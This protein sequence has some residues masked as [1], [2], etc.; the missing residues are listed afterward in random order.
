MTTLKFT[1]SSSGYIING[2]YAEIGCANSKTFKELAVTLYCP[3]C[4]AVCM[5][6]SQYKL[7]A[8]HGCNDSPISC[9]RCGHRKCTGACGDIE[10]F[11][12]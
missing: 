5:Q 9:K 3:N 2:K 6:N 11:A 10:Y 12:K 8:T 4:G 1:E 7:I